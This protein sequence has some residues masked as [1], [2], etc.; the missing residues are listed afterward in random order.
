M[1]YISFIAGTENLT[2][3]VTVTNCTINWGLEIGLFERVE[4]RNDKRRAFISLSDKAAEAMARY[5]AAIGTEGLAI[6]AWPR[7]RS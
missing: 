7:F 6:A 5:F 1:S 4:D 3:E 2:I